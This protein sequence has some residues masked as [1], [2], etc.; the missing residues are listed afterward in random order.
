MRPSN[1]AESWFC[2]SHILESFT[3]GE[4]L[5]QSSQEVRHC[6]IEA[7]W[8]FQVQQVT[9]IWQ[10]VQL[11]TLDGGVRRLGLTRGGDLVFG[12]MQHQGRDPDVREQR[13]RIW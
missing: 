10:D 7:L 12:A 1:Q 3:A 8:L 6:P 13:S 4:L 9:G 2:S 5:N 11:R